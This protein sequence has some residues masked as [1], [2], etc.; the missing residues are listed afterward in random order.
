[1]EGERD[2]GKHFP[3]LFIITRKKWKKMKEK[4]NFYNGNFKIP[5]K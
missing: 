5:H 3:I 2:K 4:Q 1:L